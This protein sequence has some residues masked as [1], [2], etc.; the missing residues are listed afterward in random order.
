M[1]GSE[2]QAIFGGRTDELRRIIVESV[3]GTHERHAAAQHTINPKGHRAYGSSIW[4]ELPNNL[5]AAVREAFISASKW[6][7]SQS[8]YSL[9][10]LEGCIFFVW[11]PAGGK[12]SEEVPFFTSAL[13][14]RL[15]AGDTVTE[16]TLFERYIEEPEATISELDEIDQLVS[17][18]DAEQRRLILI[19]V[20]SRPARLHAIKWGEVR[21][22]QDLEL[23]WL[24]EETLFTFEEEEARPVRVAERTFADGNLPESFVTPRIESTNSDE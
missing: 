1:S 19:V 21:R 22:G 12:S 2:L 18:A 13:R 23:E 10:V 7:D 8:R 14:E 20:E 5:E 3:R 9:P 16:P 4:A 6:Q 17:E 11:R 15:V 24:S